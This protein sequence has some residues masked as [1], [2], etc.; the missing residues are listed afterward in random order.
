MLPPGC[1]CEQGAAPTEYDY[2]PAPRVSSISTSGGPASLASEAGTSV[3]TA[4]GVG[5]DPL[6]IDWADFG[7]PQQAD[8][9]D[10]NYAFVS[11]TELQVI[12]PPQTQ[13]VDPAAVPFSVKTLGGQSNSVTALY[14]G[15]PTISSVVNTSS[16]TELNGV[17]G[18]PDTGGTPITV[19]G[20]GFADQLVAPLQ[21]VDT[22]K[23]GD[24]DGTQYT[25]TVNGDTS[26]STQTVSQNPALVDVEACT[27]SGCSTTSP[28][29]EFWLYPPG[30]PQVDAVKPS[31]GPAAGD[32]PVAIT[33]ENLSCPISALFGNTAAETVKAVAT[34]GLD[35]GSS[36][37]LKATSPAGI[38]G[39]TVPVTVQTVESYFTGAPT[40]PT[41]ANFT[42]GQ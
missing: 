26:L 7:D 27:V 15:V 14:A 24:S 11:G 37:K 22:E 28:A 2:V 18:G 29:D 31:S 3:V 1:D 30:N 23:K 36:A 21:F 33:G 34:P 13:T 4:T 6:A 10:I 38:A 35:C 20:Q 32:T 5:F 12:A 8:S 39:S 16:S 41:T 17:Y 9:Q 19:T 40:S 42:Y 25:F